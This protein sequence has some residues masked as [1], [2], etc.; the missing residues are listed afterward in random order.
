LNVFKYILAFLKLYLSELSKKLTNLD[1]SNNQLLNNVN[2]FSEIENI[3]I[4]IPAGNIY[5]RNFQFP[6]GK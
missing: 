4:N 2:K 6:I 5:T 1:G 3:S